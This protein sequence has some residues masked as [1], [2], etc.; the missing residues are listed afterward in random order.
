[1]KTLLTAIARGITRARLTMAENDL[2]WTEAR[3]AACI[4]TQ[5][6]RVQALAEQLERLEAG[7]GAP[8]SVRLRP[9]TAEDV[10][11]RIERRLKEHLL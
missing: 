7:R 11:V 2:A 3:G 4:R 5:R 6:A 1:M 9:I 8:A 10:R